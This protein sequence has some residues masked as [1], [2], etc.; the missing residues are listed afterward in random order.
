MYS[1]V[2]SL[3][4]VCV[5]ISTTHSVHVE[6]SKMPFKWR[7]WHV[8]LMKRAANSFKQTVS[9]PQ[10]THTIYETCGLTEILTE[11]LE[12]EHKWLTD[13]CGCKWGCVCDVFA[14]CC[15][16]HCLTLMMGPIWQRIHTH[17]FR[18]LR[19]SNINEKCM[20]VI[21]NVC[22]HIPTDNLN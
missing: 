2:L 16:L 22:W 11:M 15:H 1:N 14:I 18:I 4:C 13:K 19:I 20:Q 8:D 9:C 5:C 6:S 10:G 3:V 12:H 17:T 21:C 7:K